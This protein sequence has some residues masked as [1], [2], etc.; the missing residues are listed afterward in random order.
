MKRNQK[1][2]TESFAKLDSYKPLI[3][4]RLT[5]YPEL[6]AVRLFGEVRAAGYAGKRA[7]SPS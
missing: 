4:E 3:H 6:T 2:R 7:V 5:T 1:L